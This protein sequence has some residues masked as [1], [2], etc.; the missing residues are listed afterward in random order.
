[1][2]LP[3]DSRFKTQPDISV[4]VLDGEAVLLNTRTGAYFS[5][6]KVGTHIW[7]LYGAGQTAA[8]VLAGVRERF[9]VEPE[10]AETDLQ[11]LTEKLLDRGLLLPA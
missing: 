2:T 7:Q 6:N 11:N 10:R 5:L 3:P 1:M 8:E 9:A 4:R